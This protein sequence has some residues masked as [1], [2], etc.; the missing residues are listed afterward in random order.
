MGRHL[1]ALPASRHGSV[2]KSLPGSRGRRAVSP[3]HGRLRLCLCPQP[4]LRGSSLDWED[5]GKAFWGQM[6][7]WEESG[8]PSDPVGRGCLPPG[9]FQK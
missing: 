9:L 3:T 8:S 7:Q 1:P 6:P 2:V 5:N 4:H